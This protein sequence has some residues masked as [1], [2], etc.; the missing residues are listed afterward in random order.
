[1]GVAAIPG[2]DPSISEPS[3]SCSTAN[4]VTTLAYIAIYISVYNDSDK[5]TTGIPLNISSVGTGSSKPKMFKSLMSNDPAFC[6]GEG[7]II[8]PLH[9]SQDLEALT[10]LDFLIFLEGTGS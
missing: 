5:Q 7:S 8:E 2:G 4:K 10:S 9:V 3:T 1:M 6:I